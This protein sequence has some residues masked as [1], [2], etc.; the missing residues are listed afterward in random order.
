MHFTAMVFAQAIAAVGM[1]L[2]VNFAKFLIKVGLGKN[3]F[4]FNF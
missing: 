1:R 4:K 3:S 2:D